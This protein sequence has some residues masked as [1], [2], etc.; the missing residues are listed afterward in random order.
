MRPL[1]AD[2]ESK[3][4]LLNMARAWVLVARQTE[5]NFETKIS[6]TVAPKHS[7][8]KYLFPT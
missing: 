5:K 3:L 8:S 4:A 6:E 2:S 1:T 7:P